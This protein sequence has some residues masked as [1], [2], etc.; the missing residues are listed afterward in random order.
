MKQK[1][2]G[3]T[4]IELLVVISIIGMLAL[5]V[6]V[7]LQSARDKGRVASAILF[8]TT[9][10]RGWGADAFGVWNFDEPN[11]SNA[12]DSGPNNITL[13]KND[14]ALRSTDTPL[15]SGKSLDFV[16][17]MAKANGPSYT[18]SI[19]NY[20]DLTKYTTS[21]W[22]NLPVGFGNGTTFGLYSAGGARIIYVNLAA[23]QNRVFA[24][25]Q[26][27]SCIG[28]NLFFSYNYPV[29]KWVN[30]TFSWDG[31]NSRLYVDGKLASSLTGCVPNIPPGDTTPWKP[32]TLYVGSGI[33]GGGSHFLGLIDELAIY[34]NV[35]TADAIQ[36]IYAEGVK[37]HNLALNTEVQPQY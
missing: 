33:S 16:T 36:Q 8:S 35:L 31:S 13:A 29:S 19:N 14:A 15:S 7:S 2:L 10:Y 28:G 26:L 34:P 24:G 22:F 27:A 11:A 12:Q 37:R 4:L 23:D 21:F 20:G 1:N 17:G 5:V 9:M 32:V 18:G 30:M 25:P 6:L 3:F